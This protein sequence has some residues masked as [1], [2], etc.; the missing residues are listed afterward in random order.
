MILIWLS[1][2]NLARAI[3]RPASFVTDNG[4][5]LVSM[6]V[7][8]RT[9]DQLQYATLAYC[10]TRLFSYRA[11]VKV[12]PSSS[13][14]A[15]DSHAVTSGLIDVL[16]LTVALP[17]PMQYNGTQ[18]LFIGV[19][20]RGPSVGSYIVSPLDNNETELNALKI[21][22]DRFGSGL[23]FTA[24][25]TVRSPNLRE[26]SVHI[27][28]LAHEDLL[29]GR[30]DSF[31]RLKIESSVGLG[32]VFT[33]GLLDIGVCSS[34]ILGDPLQCMNMV[35]LPATTSTAPSTTV[36]ST[37]STSTLT[38]S[39]IIT[40]AT[41]PQST[42][43]IVGSPPPSTAGTATTTTITTTFTLSPTSSSANVATSAS[44]SS[45]A[46]QTAA[47]TQP[48]SFTPMLDVSAVS[49]NT[50]DELHTNSRGMDIHATTPVSNLNA[51]DTEILPADSTPALAVKL[52]IAIAGGLLAFC[53]I[54]GVAVIAFFACRRRRLAMAE[55]RSP[56]DVPL[57]GC[58][59]PPGAISHIY[60]DVTSVRPAAQ[61]DQPTRA[62][63]AAAYESP[64]STFTRDAARQTRNSPN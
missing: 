5:E 43:T 59:E 15:F 31:S 55:K 57:K 37:T 63:A 38:F 47:S 54:I 7:G 23:A 48:N 28:T 64:M 49:A 30:G 22:A 53:L 35:T 18:L 29:D 1:C 41:L 26:V 12:P 39:S 33:V 6:T 56:G 62:A 42:S 40:T 8:S 9:S 14:M 52:Q 21:D 44:L 4:D 34:P 20:N 45:F 10:D 13:Q 60:D 58:Q 36:E 27:V 50:A 3:V 51:P 25:F 16:S 19:L 11:E 61:N 2:L 24:W 46:A 32:D 17:T